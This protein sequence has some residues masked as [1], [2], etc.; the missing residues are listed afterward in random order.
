MVWHMAD[1]L[2]KKMNPASVRP[3][4]AVFEWH[5]LGDAVLALPFVRAAELRYEV[6]VFCRPAAAEIFQWLLPAP[7]VHGCEPPWG[8]TKGVL[9]GMTGCGELLAQIRAV[10]AELGVCAWADP[11]VS[12]LMTRAGIARRVGFPVTRPNYFTWEAA[13]EPS[14]FAQV[15]CYSLLATLLQRRGLLTVEVNRA[16]YHQAR[17]EDWR[18]LGGKTGVDVSLKTPWFV[19]REVLP[20]RVLER[21]KR[22]R[23]AG[24]RVWLVHPGARLPVKRWPAHSFACLLRNR[25]KACEESV[26]VLDI[27]G[28]NGMPDDIPAECRFHVA[29]PGM[30][31]AFINGADAVLCHDSL[32]AHLASALGKPVV[33]LFGDMPE[34]WF[35]PYENRQHVVKT[36]GKAR[37]LTH[38]ELEREGKTLLDAVTVEAVQ[39]AMSRVDGQMRS[40]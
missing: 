11:R 13:L 4:L 14:R 30:L 10:R 9:P 22:A 40:S 29:S 37:V 20:P 28:E 2:E 33:A 6:H 23:L 32:P 34:C 39:A 36:P 21:F 15:Y 25:I 5:H 27:P 35:G 19:P 26:A 7:H 8:E 16:D 38:R 18:Q 12:V 31:A 17:W 3:V 1:E 24:H